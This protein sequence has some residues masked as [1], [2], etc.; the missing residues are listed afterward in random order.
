M[1]RPPIYCSHNM[2]VLELLEKQ[3]KDL[4]AHRCVH[5]L[6][7]HLS[8]FTLGKMCYYHSAP[9]LTTPSGSEISIFPPATWTHFEYHKLT[10]S[11]FM[12]SKPLRSLPP[13]TC[14]YPFSF[15]CGIA[16]FQTDMPVTVIKSQQSQKSSPHNT[17]QSVCSKGTQYRVLIWEN[18]VNI[19]PFSFHILIGGDSGVLA[20]DFFC[21]CVCDVSSGSATFQTVIEV[22]KCRR[23]GARG[24]REEGGGGVLHCV[25]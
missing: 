25:D 10:I 17:I 9:F 8:H 11:M 2:G 14:V 6:A 20:K 5:W 4:H 19:Q 24:G 7:I 13:L 3:R 23:A 16:G 22:W 1:E 21:V 18:V 12:D 15:V